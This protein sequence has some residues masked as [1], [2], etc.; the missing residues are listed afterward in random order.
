M[1][2]P[3]QIVRLGGTDEAREG[4]WK[5]INEESFTCQH[6]KP[7]DNQPDNRDGAQ[8]YLRMLASSN[9]DDFEN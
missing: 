7:E 8:H 3:R 1:I 9:W 6:W 5:W 2:E 4:R